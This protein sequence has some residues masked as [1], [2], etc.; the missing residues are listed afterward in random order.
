MYREAFFTSSIH[1]G[2][3]AILS[4]TWGE[5]ERERERDCDDGDEEEEEEEEDKE[6]KVT[7]RMDDVR[8]IKVKSLMEA[9]KKM[10]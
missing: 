1:H 8:G 5:R 4:E 10:C 9:E 6:R 3:H 2:I 7:K